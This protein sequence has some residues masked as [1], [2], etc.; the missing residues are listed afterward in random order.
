MKKTYPVRVI[1]IRGEEDALRELTSINSTLEGVRLMR[2]KMLCR[3][4]RVDNLP[5]QAANIIKQEMLSAG[6]DAAISA[7]ALE[8][9]TSSTSVLLMGNLKQLAY[10]IKKLHQQPFGLDALGQEIGHVLEAFQKTPAPLRLKNKVFDWSQKTYIMGILNLTPDSFSDGGRYPSTE[11]AVE[12][13]LEMIREGADMIDIGGESSRPGSEPISVEEEMSRILP[14]IEAILQKKEIVVSVDT[15]K[16]DVARAALQ[17]GALLVNDITGLK[18]DAGM[19]RVVREFDAGVVLM[20]M[21]GIPKSMQE[22]PRYQDLMG[23]IHVSL[24]ESVGQAEQAGIP[25][26]K[27]IIDPGMGFGKTLE[28]NLEILD[29]LEELKS[30]GLPILLGASRKAFIGRILDLPVEERLEGSLGVAALG[31]VRGA[32]L[33]RVHDVKETARMVKMMDAALKKPSASPWTET[34]DNTFHA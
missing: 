21:K 27:M 34:E 2:K 9:R 18:G 17:K 8:G 32:G 6:G 25:R 28:H 4:V 33:L 30:L 12:Q 13:A 16:A 19:A 29:R 11:A 7:G 22:D 24:V 1:A 3:A 15:T 14:V 23:E 26:E 20:H 31:I 10:G 5:F